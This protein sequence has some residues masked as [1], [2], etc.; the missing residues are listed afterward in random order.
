[1][2]IFLNFYFEIPK[3]P[4]YQII[5]WNFFVLLAV[6]R[7]KWSR[8]LDLTFGIFSLIVAE[9]L[10]IYHGQSRTYDY[11]CDVGTIFFQD[12]QQNFCLFYKTLYLDICLNKIGQVSKIFISTFPKNQDFEM[13]LDF[14]FWEYRELSESWVYL[15]LFWFNN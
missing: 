3:N 15:L 6:R 5:L 9:I 14:F 4:N 8:V 12:L 10:K 7:I 11:E 1:L 2:A 13:I